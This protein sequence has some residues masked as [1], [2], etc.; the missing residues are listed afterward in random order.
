MTK[1]S[2]P[3]SLPQGLC[4]MHNMLNHPCRQ[5]LQLER[6]AASSRARLSKLGRLRGLQAAAQARK[7]AEAAERAQAR[8]TEQ[9]LLEAEAS[10]SALIILTAPT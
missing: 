2:F 8:A 7:T 3:S 10:R 5:V 1:T 4:I 9:D 6:E